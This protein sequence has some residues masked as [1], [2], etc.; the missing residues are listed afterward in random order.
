MDYYIGGDLLTLISKYEDG[1]PEDMC[2]FYC[3]EIILGTKFII[4]FRL[5]FNLNFCIKF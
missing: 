2:R 3:S 1:L 5:I 4:K